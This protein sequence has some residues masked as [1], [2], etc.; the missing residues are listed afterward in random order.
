MMLRTTG[1]MLAIWA[2]SLLFFGA[3]NVA[4]AT[5]VPNGDFEVDA[6]ANSAPDDW[7]S[8]GTIGYVTN[9]DSDGVGTSSVSAGNGGDWRSTAFAVAA[10]EQ[11]TW[12]VDYKVAQ[13]STGTFRADLRFFT[14]QGGDGG[15][16]G[17]FQG[18]DVHQVDVSGVTPGVWQTLGPFTINV[19]AGSL[20]P[21]LVPNFADIR[22]SAGLFG[23][24]L[25]GELR[26][27]NISV[28]RIPEPAT[29]S[30]LAMA[31]VT[32]V[33]ATRSRRR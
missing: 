33:A 13:G 32:G 26:F 4:Q 5:L 29:M 16:A 9:D 17:S 28:T 25:V 6:E 11:L 19:P 22:I 21:L 14:G 15:T 20:P 2:M 23:D 10:N 3:A 30:L 27:D 31:G 7:F 8:G 12:S 24:P 1:G 18:E